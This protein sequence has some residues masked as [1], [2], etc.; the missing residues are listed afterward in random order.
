MLSR[1]NRNF[2]K[3]V[4]AQSSDYYQPFAYISESLRFF[5]QFISSNICLLENKWIKWCQH[6]PVLFSF[7]YGVFCFGLITSS[8]TNLK[9]VKTES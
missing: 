5:V 1:K 8:I 7:F 3:V 9:A 6:C 2:N 4:F